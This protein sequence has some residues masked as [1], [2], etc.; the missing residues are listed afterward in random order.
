MT[1]AHYTMSSVATVL[2]PTVRKSGGGQIVA[3][4][5]L[6]SME[7]QD[8]VANIIV[9][10]IECMCLLLKPTAWVDQSAAHFR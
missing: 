9:I 3:I 2:Q 1:I 10:F 5:S 6:S 7:A 8:L 4:L